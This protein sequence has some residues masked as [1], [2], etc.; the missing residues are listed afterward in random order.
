MQYNRIYVQIR[1]VLLLQASVLC[2]FVIFTYFC[3]PCAH[4]WYFISINTFQISSSVLTNS[5][6]SDHVVTEELTAH[7]F[8][9]LIRFSSFLTAY[10][11]Q[12]SFHFAKMFALSIITPFFA[13]VLQ[14]TNSVITWTRKIVFYRFSPFLYYCCRIR[15]S[16]LPSWSY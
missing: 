15:V 13:E 6:I 3:L 11:L 10:F 16:K 2:V 5:P 14:W 8:R 12:I 9:R 7:L 4:F 1:E